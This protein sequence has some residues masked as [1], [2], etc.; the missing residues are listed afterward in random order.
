[1]HLNEVAGIVLTED[2]IAHPFGVSDEICG[3]ENN[4]SHEEYFSNEI[5]TQS[6]FKKLNIAFEPQNLYYQIP[7]MT[8][9]NLTFILNASSVSHNKHDV[10]TY[11]IFAPQQ[12]SQQTKDYFSKHYLEF[13][14]LID[15]DKAFFQADTF[16]DGKYQNSMPIGNLDKFYEFMNIEKNLKT[17]K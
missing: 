15:R 7:E 3:A 8:S 17:L 2:G 6:W 13:K 9:Y 10:Y 14:N 5:A 16:Q 12:L 11:A 4:K 1:M